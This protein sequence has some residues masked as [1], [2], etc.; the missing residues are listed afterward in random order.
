MVELLS[1]TE[2]LRIATK[3]SRL[4]DWLRE[5]EAKRSEGLAGQVIASVLDSA[6]RAMG[7]RPLEAE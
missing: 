5:L 3:Y 6:Y 7:E 1:N 2:L 4:T